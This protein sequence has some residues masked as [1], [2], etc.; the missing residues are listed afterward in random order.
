MPNYRKR[1]QKLKNKDQSAEAEILQDLFYDF[2]LHRGRIYRVNFIRGIFFG[3][4]TF[5]GGT[6]IIAIIVAILSY[7]VTIPGGLGDFIQFIIDTI[8]SR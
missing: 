4:G 6:V 5:L 1:Q 3:L 2:Y 8:K 7:L